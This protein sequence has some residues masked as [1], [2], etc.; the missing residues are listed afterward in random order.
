MRAPFKVMRWLAAQDPAP[1]PQ[2]IPLPVPAEHPQGRTFPKSQ[3]PHTLS[4]KTQ[5]QYSLDF[6]ALL[7][8]KL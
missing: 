6:I 3:C 8:P 1:G 4:E 5:R 2:L 7:S